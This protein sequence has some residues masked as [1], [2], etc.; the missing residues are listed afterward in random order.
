MAGG[1]RETGL[2]VE[3]A[4][5]LAPID[6]AIARIAGARNRRRNAPRRKAYRFSAS[7]HGLIQPRD[8]AAPHRVDRA[9]PRGRLRD[10]GLAKRRTIDVGEFSRD[11]V[12]A[13]SRETGA[14]ARLV[15]WTKMD[16]SDLFGAR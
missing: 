13:E 10:G 1:R 11:L 16:C 4:R 6:R 9:I 7:W 15:D 14:S 12:R 2:F 5:Y 3:A 8:D